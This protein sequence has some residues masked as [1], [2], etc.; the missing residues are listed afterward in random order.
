MPKAP[1]GEGAPCPSCISRNPVRLSP[2]GRGWPAVQAGR[3]RGPPCHSCVSRNPAGVIPAQAAVQSASPHRGRGRRCPRYRRVRG[4]RVIPA[5]AAVQSAS[6]HRG[7]GRLRSR[8]GEG[9]GR[10]PACPLVEE[11]SLPCAQPTERESIP[12]PLYRKGCLSIQVGRVAAARQGVPIPILP[13]GQ[14]IPED[15]SS[16]RLT[17]PTTRR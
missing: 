15:L 2:C 8:P 14:N 13:P 6:P 4:H 3:V 11:P 9:E 10:R 7:R 17:A 16:P 1:P 12:S 5:Q